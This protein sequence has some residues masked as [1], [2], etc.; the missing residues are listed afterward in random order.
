[1]ERSTVEESYRLRTDATLAAAD[2]GGLSLH[3]TRFRLPL[4]ALG[5]GGRALLLGLAE[6]WIDDLELHRLVSGLE[7][8]AQVLRAQVLL[9][10]LIA[11]SWLRR[12][13][14]SG[15]RELIDVVPRG[16]GAGS[17]PPARRHDP[18]TGYRMSR[19][20]ALQPAGD[21][22]RAQSPL[23]P[24]MVDCVDPGTAALLATGAA[25]LDPARAAEVLGTGRHAADRVLDEL[26]TARIL[27]S[28]ADHQAE[29][30][31]PRLA[32]WSAS[33]LRLHERSRPGTHVA[34]VGGTYPFRARFAPAPL[35]RE[36]LG[37]RMVGLPVPD[38]ALVAKRDD[39]L[40]D[41]LTARRS[42]RVHDDARPVTAEQLGEFLY[43]V[44]RTE[45]LGEAGGQQVGKRP[46]PT[47]GSLCELEIY[48]VVTRCA[49]LDAGL[50][51][52]DAVGHRLELLAERGPA[53]DR[54]VEYARGAAAM[55][56]PPQVLLVITARVDRLR[57]KYEGL[58]YSLMLK[59][60]GV[61]TGL[62]YLVATAMGLAPC[63][64]G[65]GHSAAFAELA[66]LDPLAEPSIADFALG[67]RATE[68]RS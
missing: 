62:M 28:D 42:V 46:Y 37:G 30:T 61:L 15:G 7:G 22:L 16:L 66:G 17:A 67:S 57:W 55:S 40:T 29:R 65:A 5:V 63:A 19:F 25:G 35:R 50:Y 10:R 44:Q 11:H 23:S 38:M 43:R 27:V 49:G 41:V 33:E 52:Y 45:Q 68:E 39:P 3:Q 20:A 4:P 26:V 8:E 13:I 31:D 32:Y 6:R 2:D 64:L 21:R 58:S 34:P 14:R 47:A 53:R 60:A 1:M 54:L 18:G 56:A 36:P 51:H 9:R 59:D 24:L 12:R 48:P